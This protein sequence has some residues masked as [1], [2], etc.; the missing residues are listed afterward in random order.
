MADPCKRLGS[1]AAR[2]CLI[3]V[4]PVLLACGATPETGGDWPQFRGTG[5]VGLT[6]A[7]GLPERWST[8]SE[9][10]RWRTEIPGS[11]NSSPIVSR[12]RVFLTT[13]VSEGDRVERSVVAIDAGSGELLWQTSIVEEPLEATHRLNTYAAPTPVTDGRTVYAFFG[14]TLAAVDRDGQV[15]WR[16][17][18]DPEYR[19]L[20]HYGAASS[21]VLTESAVV[22]ARDREDAKHGSGWLG[23]FDQRTGE[24]LWRRTWVDTCC[25]YAT[26][27][28]LE[29]AGGPEILFTHAARV[30]SYDPDTG[31]TLWSQPLQQNQPVTTPTVEGDL[32]AV[33][34]GADRVRNGAML[35]LSGSGLETEVEILWQTRR[36]IPQVSSPVLYDGALYT[37]ADNGVMVSYEPLTGKVRWQK[38]LKGAGFRPSLLAGDGK[39]YALDSHGNASVVAAGP[40]FKLI[41]ENSIDEGGNASPAYGA[42]CLLVR[43]NDALFCIEAEPPEGA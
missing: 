14:A 37:V 42:G 16:Q 21:A 8:D 41:A 28:V 4:L 12:G 2:G 5:G 43:T 33:F 29:R 11:G 32:I 34:T 31:E 19:D 7:T 10:V 23:A 38:R 17:T 9:N 1:A 6:D 15:E 18:V 20:S 30:T 25:S 40:K 22:V 39:I 27:L 3:L 35:R 13:A 24:E 36:M 26:P